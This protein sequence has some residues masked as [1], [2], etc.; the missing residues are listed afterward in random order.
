[1]GNSLKSLLYIILLFL[2]VSV[3]AARPRKQP[4]DTVGLQCRGVMETFSKVSDGLEGR[5]DFYA[6][7][8][9][10]HYFYCPSDDRYCNRWGWKF[11]YND[12]D[13]HAVRGYK[14]LCHEKGLEFV[15]TLDPG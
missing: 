12:S 5:L 1:M 10:T 8:G 4:V 2:S 15:W 11:L 14:A 13:R 3:G 7:E 9:M 6:Q